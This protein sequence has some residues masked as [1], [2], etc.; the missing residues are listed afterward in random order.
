MDLTQV[1]TLL[2][3]TD[4]RRRGVMSLCHRDRIKQ[5]A[6]SFRSECLMYGE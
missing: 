1:T 6:L 5:L 2:L 4:A 3:R